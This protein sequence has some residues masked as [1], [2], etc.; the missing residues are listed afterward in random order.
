MYNSSKIKET[1]SR[2]IALV[3]VFFI[4]ISMSI[5]PVS[6]E[7]DTLLLSKDFEHSTSVN[8]I[9]AQN[10]EFEKTLFSQ[11]ASIEMPIPAANHLMLSLLVAEN[12]NGDDLLTLSEESFAQKDSE[13]Q[14]Q[15][16]SYQK[17]RQY[18]VSNLLVSMLYEHSRVATYALAEAVGNSITNTID[19]MNRRAQELQMEQTN[20]SDIFG[21]MTTDAGKIDSTF[22][23][24][25][26]SHTLHQK[27]SLQD[28]YILIVELLKNSMTNRIFSEKEIFSKYPS[29]SIV[30][31]HHPFEQ[32]FL[33]SDQGIRSA[34]NLQFESTSF[35]FVSGE[36]KG[37]QYLILMSDMSDSKFIHDFT[38]LIEAIDSYFAVTPLVT[39]NQIYP[40]TD[41]TVEGDE[42]S[43]VFLNTI[44]YIHPKNND[45]VNPAVEYISHG[46]H[47]RPLL[48]G[49]AIGSVI[50]TLSDGSQIEAEVGAEEAIL[51]GNTYLSKIVNGIQQNP[52]LGKLLLV[53]LSL[54]IIALLSRIYRVLQRIRQHSKLAKLNEFQQNLYEKINQ[55][56]NNQK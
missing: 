40:G 26:N 53:L 4:L 41:K 16:I 11:Q 1:L 22:D 55:K 3:I 51:S 35:S 56:K 30:A 37:N 46:P 23:Y 10:T 27:S 17:G 31:F 12:L 13:T 38:S 25:N 19:L 21:E 48:R 29:G 45:F 14:T 54:L 49:T 33:Y 8:H 6:A 47:Y 32:I 9:F 44:R 7:I 5:S 24:F 50:F 28:M 2:V 20:F 42:I 34:W 15:S 18:T 52:N 36:F 43:L 39:Q